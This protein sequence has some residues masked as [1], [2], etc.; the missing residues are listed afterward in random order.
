MQQHPPMHWLNAMHICNILMILQLIQHVF[1][2]GIASA[3]TFMCLFGAFMNLS[4]RRFQLNI[5]K[6]IAEISRREPCNGVEEENFY[7]EQY[8]EAQWQYKEHFETCSEFK[9]TWEI[10]LFRS[11]QVMRFKNLDASSLMLL[12]N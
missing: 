4:C 2:G 7:E 12:R 6:K 5:K 9:T 1:N 3:I 11:L 8:N 10:L